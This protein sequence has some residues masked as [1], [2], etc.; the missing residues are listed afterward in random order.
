[1]TIN[2]QDLTSF[3]SSDQP[4][5]QRVFELK[6]FQ[7]GFF[8]SWARYPA[9]VSGW[10]TGKSLTGILRGTRLSEEYPGNL[11]LIVRREFVDLRDSTMKDFEKYTGQ[12]INKQDKEYKFPNG[13]IIMFRHASELDA[14]KNI[15]LGWFWIEQA[16]ELESDDQ[17]FFLQGRLRRENV[18]FRTG[19]ITANACG[20]NWIWGHWPL[21]G[22]EQKDPDYPAWEA[23][24]YDNADVLVED[25]IK[26]LEGIKKRRL[27]IYNQYVMNDHETEAGGNWIIPIN[28]IESAATVHFHSP[29]EKRI[30]TCDPASTGDNIMVVYAM[31]NTEIIQEK[32]FPPG[33]RDPMKLAGE[34]VVLKRKNNASLIV[35][36]GIGVG[37]GICSRLLELGHSVLSINSAKRSKDSKQFLNTRAEMW[38]H[39]ADL[40]IDHKV[41][42]GDITKFDFDI[43]KKQ[44]SNVRYEVLKSNGKTKIEE[45]D[46][47]KKRLGCSPD[48]ADAYVMG[49]YGLQFA[50]TEDEIRRKKD[51]YAYEEPAESSGFMGS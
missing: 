3:Q 12:H 28:L 8:T 4:N 21:G 1:M 37:E 42:F 35:V 51:P 23:T 2:K 41:S 11:G 48:Y 20:H 30:I 5:E 33:E 47:I 29:I 25:F 18:G 16:E 49:L 40:F 32:V 27:N 13:S 24:T 17:F 39:S 44:L 45:K 36:D 43:L 9:F 46:E 26:S 19:F 34:L 15:N 7:E 22:Q 6:P 10:A 50:K 31:R 14:L 38:W